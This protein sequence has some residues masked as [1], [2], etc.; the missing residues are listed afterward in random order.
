MQRV[1]VAHDRCR[2]AREM[3][4][5]VRNADDVAV[6]LQGLRV[7]WFERVMTQQHIPP[8]RPEAR[9]CPRGPS[10]RGDGWTRS[11]R[12]VFR[13]Q[14]FESRIH[15]RMLEGDLP[16]VAIAFAVLNRCIRIGKTSETLAL[17]YAA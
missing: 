11:L 10:L 5:P 9:R 1:V 12:L 6:A 17:P 7:V 13:G 14:V 8:A 15:Q 2:D 16:D 4:K 3:R